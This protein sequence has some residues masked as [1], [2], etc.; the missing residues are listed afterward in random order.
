M[1][2]LF[3]YLTDWF[4]RSP[5]DRYVVSGYQGTPLSAPCPLAEARKHAKSLANTYDRDFCITNES[6]GRGETISPDRD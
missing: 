5:G 3:R 2:R 1:N 6:T 4:V